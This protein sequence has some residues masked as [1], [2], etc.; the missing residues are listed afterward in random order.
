MVDRLFLS[1]A[2][3]VPLLEEVRRGCCS[4]VSDARLPTRD[5]MQQFL[6]RYVL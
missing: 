5:A 6:E 4:S 1:M 2:G 3:I